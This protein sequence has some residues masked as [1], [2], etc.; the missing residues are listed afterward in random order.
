MIINPNQFDDPVLLFN[1]TQETQILELVDLGVAVGVSQDAQVEITTMIVENCFRRTLKDQTLGGQEP[2]LINIPFPQVQ[3]AEGCR[4]K[5]YEE[6]FLINSETGKAA[7]V[8]I[9]RL[10]FGEQIVI[11]GIFVN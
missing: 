9:D 2:V 10:N 3:V 5:G 6:F 4:D 1:K 7:H 11:L 8:A